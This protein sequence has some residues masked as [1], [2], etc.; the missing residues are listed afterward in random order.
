MTILL[1]SPLIAAYSNVVSEHVFCLWRSSSHGHG[2]RNWHHS[3]DDTESSPQ[4]AFAVGPRSA[5]EL[6]AWPKDGNDSS[7]IYLK[8]LSF[9][10]PGVFLLYIQLVTQ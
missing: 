3:D 5:E 7:R 1:F 9:D 10:V 2:S 8:F 4:V 6:V